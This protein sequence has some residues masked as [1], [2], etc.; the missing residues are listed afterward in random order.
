MNQIR[1]LLCF[2]ILKY[3]EAA[4]RVALPGRAKAPGADRVSG[5]WRQLISHRQGTQATATPCVPC[6]IL[7]PLLLA[8]CSCF[9]SLARCTSP[10]YLGG[11]SLVGGRVEDI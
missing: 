1:L 4:S 7:L 8:N 5:R 2:A 9:C 6:L 3:R 10:I 11:N